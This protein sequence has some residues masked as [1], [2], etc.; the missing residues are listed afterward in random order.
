[1][2]HP[3]E[4]LASAA[5]RW[6]GAIA[7][8][9]PHKWPGTVYRD[10]WVEAFEPIYD[11]LGLGIAFGGLLIADDW[12]HLAFPAITLAMLFTARRLFFYPHLVIGDSSVTIVG[13]ARTSQVP[14][15]DIDHAVAWGSEVRIHTTTPD[16]FTWWPGGPFPGRRDRYAYIADD[17]N[18][19]VRR[20]SEANA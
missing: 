4:D 5:L 3:A 10:P 20:W 1:M 8:L 15:A 13:I 17:V 19:A 14:F 18:L 2:V 11:I 6:N 12:W 9:I 16:T 7:R